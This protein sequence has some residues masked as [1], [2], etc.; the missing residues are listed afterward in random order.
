LLTLDDGGMNQA[1]E[2]SARLR[3][4]ENDVAQNPAIDRP[5]RRQNAVSELLHNGCVHGLAWLKKLM[6]DVIRFDQMT[7]EFDKHRADSALARRNSAGQADSKHQ[8]PR[9]IRAALIVFFMSVAIV[10]G[11]TP[12][13]TGEIMDATSFTARSSTSPTQM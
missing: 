2:L 8:S 5:I 10:M 7:A 9:R 3:I 4:F 6:R 13:G 11:P 1:V 12:P